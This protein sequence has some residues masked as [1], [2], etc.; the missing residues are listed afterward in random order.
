MYKGMKL[1]QVVN[2]ATNTTR[3]VLAQDIILD[4]KI[5]INGDEVNYTVADLLKDNRNNQL[6][7]NKLEEKQIKNES[8][9]RVMKELFKSMIEVMVSNNLDCSVFAETLSALN[10]K[11]EKEND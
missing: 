3:D 9:F 2:R 1:I 4:K 10:N 8:N 11:E 5:D 6:A 7:I